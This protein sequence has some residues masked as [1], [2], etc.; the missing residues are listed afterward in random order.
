MKRTTAATEKALTTSQLRA[1]VTMAMLMDRDG[2]VTQRSLAREMGIGI[3]AAH[4]FF[5]ILAK[6]GMIKSYGPK[7]YA[8]YKL[9]YRVEIYR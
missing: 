9:K 1:Y 4:G 3:N 5:V 8:A 2:R 7:T 6:L